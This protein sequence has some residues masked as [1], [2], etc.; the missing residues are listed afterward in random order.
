MQELV[1]GLA[2]YSV[3]R[4]VFFIYN[5]NKLLDKLMSRNYHEYKMAE[6][7]PS[8]EP[9]TYKGIE[10]DPEDLGILQSFN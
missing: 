5:V 9:A 7:G 1:I 8:H 2:V 10:E 3:V 6:S 4:E